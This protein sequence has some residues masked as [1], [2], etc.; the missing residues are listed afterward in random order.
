[1][2]AAQYVE[3][4]VDALDNRRRHGGSFNFKATNAGSTS[5]TI[6][7]VNATTNYL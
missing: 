6:T 7:L 2:T 5:A 3:G 1:M 4:E